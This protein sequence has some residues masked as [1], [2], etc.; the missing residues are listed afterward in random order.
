MIFKKEDLD[1]LKKAEDDYINNSL[2]DDNC[3]QSFSEVISE[4]DLW[5]LTIL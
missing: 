1:K 3:D 5:L 2:A 4:D